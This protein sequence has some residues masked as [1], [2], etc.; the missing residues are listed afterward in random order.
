MEV[1]GW[2]GPFPSPNFSIL[3]IH[4][5]PCWLLLCPHHCC[6]MSCV[7]VRL[8]AVLCSCTMDLLSVCLSLRLSVRLSLFP[9]VLCHRSPPRLICPCSNWPPTVLVAPNCIFPPFC[10]TNHCPWAPALPPR[11]PACLPACP[12]Y[13]PLSPTQ[14][15]EPGRFLRPWPA[16]SPSCPPGVDALWFLRYS[17]APGPAREEG[18]WRMFGEALED[19]E[20]CGQSELLRELEVRPRPQAYVGHS[21]LDALVCMP[22]GSKRIDGIVLVCHTYVYSHWHPL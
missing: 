18:F 7:W 17:P 16:C 5:C 4:L 1:M 14:G 9:G 2:P 13:G 22:V 10:V 20:S 19:L 8:G 21:C 15:P 6:A 12:P 3:S 11:M